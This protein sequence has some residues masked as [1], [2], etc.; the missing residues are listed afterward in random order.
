MI[1][2]VRSKVIELKGG[3]DEH[4]PALQRS[5]GTLGTCINYMIEEGEG[6]GYTSMP[7]YERVDATG[8][9]SDAIEVIL[10]LVDEANE[11]YSYQQILDG[12]AVMQ[13]SL[14]WI[15]TV[16]GDGVII[17]NTQ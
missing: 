8:K 13:G 16:I 6:G 4:S 9:P 11:E 15:I 3:V 1:R 10:E 12:Q 5:P 7:G 14:S 17:G 2:N